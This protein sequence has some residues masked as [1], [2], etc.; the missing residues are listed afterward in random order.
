[1]IRGMVILCDKMDFDDFTDVTLGEVT[2][3]FYNLHERIVSTFSVS[4]PFIFLFRLD[5]MWDFIKIVI[6]SY[7][8]DDF[9]YV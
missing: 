8:L 4:N 7:I 5:F 3:L 1:M 9:Y 2:E 6:I